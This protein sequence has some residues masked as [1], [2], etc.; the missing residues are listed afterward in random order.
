MKDVLAIGD[1]GALPPRSSTA[2]RVAPV[3]PPAVVPRTPFLVPTSGDEPPV[4]EQAS[5]ALPWVLGAAGL[6]LALVTAWAVV[7][8][9][10]PGAARR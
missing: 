5:H 6:G 3:A 1:L 4:V 7:R 2:A 8:P 10:R 9:R